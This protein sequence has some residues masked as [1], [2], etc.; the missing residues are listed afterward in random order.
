MRDDAGHE[1]FEVRVT[2]RHAEAEDI[3]SFELMRPDGG[4]LPPFRAGAHIDVVAPNGMLR[5][6]SLC[7]R[8]L[9]RQRYVIGVLRDP[10]SRG[11]SQSIHALLSVG[12]LVRIGAPR[13]HFALA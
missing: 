1:W 11:A 13:N 12:D 4:D 5:Q 8:P 3:A 10:G 2:R 9:E 7:N 6:Y